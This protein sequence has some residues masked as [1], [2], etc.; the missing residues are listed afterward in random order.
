MTATPPRVAAE[1]QELVSQFKTD[2]GD[3]DAPPTVPAIRSAAG[4][5]HAVAND[6][7]TRLNGR[8]RPAVAGRF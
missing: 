4:N 8:A 5:G 6:N 2:L 3:N 1:Q 7:G